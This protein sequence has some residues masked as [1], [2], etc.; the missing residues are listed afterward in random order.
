MSDKDKVV[1]YE[2]QIADMLHAILE[3]LEEF[4]DSKQLSEFEQGRQVAYLEMM[5]MIQS[6]HKMIIEVLN[7]E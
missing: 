5:D 6:R 3:R 2:L 7:E 4:E 1:E